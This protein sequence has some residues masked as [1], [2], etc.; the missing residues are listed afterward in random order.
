MTKESSPTV[1]TEAPPVSNRCYWQTN[2]LW[3]WTRR[4]PWL[5]TTQGEML[6]WLRGGRGRPSTLTALPRPHG[7]GFC[8]APR[9]HL[10]LNVCLRCRQCSWRRHGWQLLRQGEE[11]GHSLR[12]GPHSPQ[13]GSCVSTDPPPL[14]LSLAGVQHLREQGQQ[15]QKN[16]TQSPGQRDSL[17]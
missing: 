3:G 9:V 12:A 16:T 15:Q 7:W 13:L 2:C 6:S 14:C 8:P 4:Q 17:G 10:N 5:H 11:G 1:F